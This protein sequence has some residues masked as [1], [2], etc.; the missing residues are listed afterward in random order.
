MKFA[1]M[2]DKEY[3]MKSNDFYVGL[4]TPE[5]LKSQMNGEE[6]YAHSLP[7]YARRKTFMVDE[8]PAC[9]S[10]WLR[11]EGKMTSYFVPVPENKG[12]WLDFNKN[13]DKKYNV[14]IVVSVQGINPITGL[15]CEDAHLEQYI[16]ECPKCREKFGPERFCKKC[17]YKWPKQNYICTTGT[18]FGQLWLDG[19]RSAEGVVRQYILTQEK[20]RGVASGIVGE[21]RVF[22]IGISFFLSKEAK[23]IDQQP[24]SLREKLGG[25]CGPGCSC[26]CHVDYSLKDKL[27]SPFMRDCSDSSFG[28]ICS[29]ED[30]SSIDSS[31]VDGES[32]SACSTLGEIR[33]SGSSG[34]SSCGGSSCGKMAG[35]HFKRSRKIGSKGSVLYGEPKFFSPVHTAIDWSVKKDIVTSPDCV[36]GFYRKSSIATSSIQEVKTKK[37]EVGAGANVDQFIYDDPEPLDF[38]RNEPESIICINYALEADCQKIIESGKISL[39]GHKDGFLK[40]VPVGN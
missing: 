25:Y 18:P 3:W 39:E 20:I 1:T 32:Y 28:I 38:W 5:A 34:G 17:G 19:F 14:A 6:E 24:K 7:P 15:P 11:S 9:P 37:V 33:S 16:E 23:P 29:D 26:K 36:S 40:E 27:S 4:N 22:A 12:L 10:N 31:S 13:W 30:S 2:W 35:G 21:K 8:Y